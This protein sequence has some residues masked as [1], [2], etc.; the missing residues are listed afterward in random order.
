MQVE[1]YEING[2][3]IDKFNQYSLEVGK[4]QGTC[5][6]CSHDRKPKTQKL[7]CASYDW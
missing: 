6:L 4:T 1:E 2:F 7:K 3:S 5:P